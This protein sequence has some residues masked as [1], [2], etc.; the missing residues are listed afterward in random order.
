MK[1][2]DGTC[3]LLKGIRIPIC[4][5][6]FSRVTGHVKTW[7][8]VLLSDIYL[9]AIT[10]RERKREKRQLSHYYSISV[11]HFEGFH[12]F[13]F[14]PSHFDSVD[15]DLPHTLNPLLFPRTLGDLIRSSCQTVI[16]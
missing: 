16:S 6:T 2:L 5:V 11:T 3:S 8:S 1:K 4:F 9:S 13:T 12:E 10:K 7:M 14:P 15:K